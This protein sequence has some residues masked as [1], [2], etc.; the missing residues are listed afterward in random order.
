[1][2]KRRAKSVT[3]DPAG[4]WR[5]VESIDKLTTTLFPECATVDDLF[6]RAVKLYTNSRC[7]G[8]RELLR[9]EEEQQPNG[10]IFKKV[11][12]G[13]YL[14]ESFEG[15]FTRISN[16]GSGLLATGQR[17]RSKVVIFAETRAEWM[18]AAQACFKYNFPC[19]SWCV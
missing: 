9:E 4:P 5:S 14:W 19:E 12:L 16:F 15:V 8:T 3:G 17:P 6:I 1:M 10:R 7:L 2:W 11:V 18:I 13:E